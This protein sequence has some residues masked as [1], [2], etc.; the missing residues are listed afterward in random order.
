MPWQDK[1]RSRI[2]AHHDS[3]RLP[4]AHAAPL[5]LQM[6]STHHHHPPGAHGH[7]PHGSEKRLG[8]S[9]A[10]NLLI[11][12][13]EVIGGLLS[14]S[15]SLLSDAVHNLSD[16]ASLAISL[17]ARR[18]ARR[19]ATPSKTFGYKRAEILGAFVNL[20][21]L[22]L[23]A[24]FLVKEAIDRLVAPQPIDGTTMLIVATIGLAANVLTALLLYR[25]ARG[26]LNI[27]SAFLHIVADAISSVGVV[28]GG[29]LIL[30][31]DV[32]LIDPLLTLGI[33]AYILWHS[34]AMLRETTDILME[35]TPSD[36]DLD[37][38][39][40]AVQS[41]ERVL[42]MHHLHV[43][44]LDEATTALEAHVVIAKGDLERMETIKRTV[45]E[46]LADDFGIE[47]STLEFE[48]LPCDDPHDPHCYDHPVTDT[49]EEAVPV[50]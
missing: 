43:W 9:I 22:V 6:S 26:S 27:R 7:A 23:I 2:L 34:Y 32:Y 10:L 4:L 36:I 8:L 21:T 11:S 39:V 48:F 38:V 14:G 5:F 35:G 31:Y 46:R 29:L 15:L 20:V 3:F 30:F 28:A 18:I 50:E 44:Q 25:D 17:V 19:G 41:V 33:S 24:L 1:V 47:H 12:M 49:A 45:K 13:A 40:E 37:R 42:D 16:T